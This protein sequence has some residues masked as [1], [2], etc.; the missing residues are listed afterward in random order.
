MPQQ[1][2]RV[3]IIDELQAIHEQIRDL[4]AHDRLFQFDSA[5]E[6][7]EALSALE[8]SL[9]RREPYSL[10]IVDIQ[11]PGD[12]N[13]LAIIQKIRA[14]D[15]DIE[16]IICSTYTDAS[17]LSIADQL[18][19]CDK[20]LFLNKPFRVAEI[21]QMVKNLAAKWRLQVR[22]KSYL[23]ELAIARSL[24]ESS[25]RAK[26][27]FLGIIGHELRTPLNVILMTL[28]DLL[29]SQNDKGALEV[30]NH[31]HRSTMRLAQMVEGIMLYTDLDSAHF[32][33]LAS[34]FRLTEVLAACE[35]Q[36][37]PLCRDKNLSL[38]FLVDPDVPDSL[39]GD[40]RLLKQ[41]LI[42]LLFNSVRF[43]DRG[44]IR[45]RVKRGESVSLSAHARGKL[46]PLD[47]EFQIEDSGRGMSE[48]QLERCCQLFYQGESPRHHGRTGIGLGLNLCR[49]IIDS[50]HGLF[51]LS[52]EVN[53]GTLVKVTLPLVAGLDLTKKLEGA[54]SQKAPDRLIRRLSSE[55]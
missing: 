2:L 26:R 11:E 7:G 40:T 34:P 46:L 53:R 23:E 29:E 42:Q 39:V 48:V 4:F 16:L 55:S 35:Q 9:E 32:S 24:A 33:P 12:W 36:F 47:L 41:L 13:G 52:S 17:W 20:Y 3:L 19:L 28:E 50:M 25:D 22:N 21:K 44:F 49:K 18:G 37:S 45:L 31:S 5:Y 38:L 43:T 27:D 1:N 54:K 30:I 6:A 14:I 8:N 51:E 10:A 15:P